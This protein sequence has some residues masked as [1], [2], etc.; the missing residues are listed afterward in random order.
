MYSILLG[1]LLYRV[2]G[3]LTKIKVPKR[4]YELVNAG[5]IMDEPPQFVALERTWQPISLSWKFLT[6]SERVNPQHWDHWALDHSD[7][8]VG[9]CSECGGDICNQGED[10]L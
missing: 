10:V 3:W 1:K 9:K 4:S 6:W 8:N 7:C 2:A 5:K